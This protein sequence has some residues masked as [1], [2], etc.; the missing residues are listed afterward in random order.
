[1]KHLRLKLAIGSLLLIPAVTAVF[2]QEPPP[3]PARPG[4]PS[5]PYVP[6]TLT[7]P[8][9]PY[10]TWQGRYRIAYPGGLEGSM[11]ITPE[12]VGASVS[13]AQNNWAS[14]EGAIQIQFLDRL[15][16]IS[17]DPE[18]IRKVLDA[19]VQGALAN[20][21]G[22]LIYDEAVQLGSVQGRKFKVRHSNGVDV[23]ARTYF[24]GTRLYMV[25]GSISANIDGAEQLISKV[26]DS[27]EILSQAEID[28]E[29]A[30][31]VEAATPAMLPQTPVAARPTTD[32][33]DDGLKGKV[34]MLKLE[35][36][37]LS[38][39]WQNQ[40]RHVSSVSEFNQA[41]ERIKRISH[42]STGY[43]FEITVYGYIDGSRVSD[44][45]M[46]RSNSGGSTLSVLTAL[47]P[48]QKPRDERYGYKLVYKHKDGRLAEVQWIQ[49][50]GSLCSGTC[51]NTRVT[52]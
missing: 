30:R 7:K 38:G 40:T 32:A 45:E 16:D 36:Q 12:T 31:A 10:S 11:P 24:D 17:T 48:K 6:P 28:A 34:R 15:T 42:D 22:K 47:D 9:K 49:N 21:K 13:G 51:T 33:V 52:H 19:G 5:R 8:G 23:L 39:K 50:D 18:W 27:F 26:L 14:R 41:G 37:D 1:M 2:A 29:V 4:T 44:S 35:N 3:P 25:V 43:P 20:T 46:L